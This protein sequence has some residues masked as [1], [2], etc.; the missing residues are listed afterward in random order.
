M[1]VLDRYDDPSAGHLEP[2]LRYGPEDFA[3]PRMSHAKDRRKALRKLLLAGRG[4]TQGELCEL[5]AA[6]GMHTTQSTVSRDLRLL[7][8][9]R[10]IRE[11]GSF[12]YRIE[13]D[14][15]SEFPA[16]MVL[17]VE[18]NE[19]M[20]VIRTL[21]GRAPVV[22]VELD[23]LRHPDVLGTLAGDDTVLVIPTNTARIAALVT[24]LRDLSERA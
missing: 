6:R 2:S 18:H 5:L 15:R 22:G 1:S 4:S 19:A 21:V 24:A 13:S 3:S 23:A 7:G 8:A 17:S 12:V 10:R 11:D 9:R 20:I 14:R 16:H